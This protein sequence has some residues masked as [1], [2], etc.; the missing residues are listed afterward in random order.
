MTC[1]QRY[2]ICDVDLP[3]RAPLAGADTLAEA[4]AAVVELHVEY[5]RQ[6]DANGE[7]YPAGGQNLLV[8]DTLHGPAGVGADVIYPHAAYQ[9]GVSA[10]H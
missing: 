4:V 7:G 5:H 8:V 10:Y 9:S 3:D 1:S 2:Q 6:L